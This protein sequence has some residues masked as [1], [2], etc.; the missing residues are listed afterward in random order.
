MNNT[1][2]SFGDLYYIFYFFHNFHTDNS[3]GG[4]LVYSL[5]LKK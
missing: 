1:D 4:I 2:N 5:N 3:F